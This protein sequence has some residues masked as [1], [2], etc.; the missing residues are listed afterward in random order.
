[1]HW[2]RLVFFQ[3]FNCHG[4]E[5]RVEVE[6]RFLAAILGRHRQEH[7][8]HDQAIIGRVCPELEAR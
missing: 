2:D 6:R 7:P 3:C 8:D 1:M 5:Q 4:R